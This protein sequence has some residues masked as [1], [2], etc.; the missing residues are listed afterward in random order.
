MMKRLTIAIVVLLVCASV[1]VASSW[2]N[3]NQPNVG[4][5]FLYDHTDY[6]I[7][8]S[9]STTGLA[10]I[11]NPL[12]QVVLWSGTIPGGSMGLNGT[13]SIVPVWSYTNSSNTKTFSIYF[14]GVAFAAP[15]ATT[16][17]AYRYLQTIQ[18]KQS[19]SSQLAYNGP[20]FGGVT[21]P[22]STSS[23]NT[24]SDQVI[25]I[26]AIT[27]LETGATVSAVTGDGATCT[28]TYGNNGMA[29]GEYVQAAGGATCSTSGTP[30]GDP[31]ALVTAVTNTITYPCTCNGTESGTKPTVK[32]YSNIT[33]KSIDVEIKRP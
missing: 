22:I 26:R 19:E 33:L 20:S 11:S 10:W 28:A 18:N 13:L 24:S 8:T 25:Q 7:Y 30:N 9:L 23:I 21:S 27:T 12:G 14:G 32:R 29:A 5:L 2:L 3:G 15:S 31:V 6:S 4:T 16:T 1:A 17:T